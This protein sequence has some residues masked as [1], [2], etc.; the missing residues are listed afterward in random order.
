M[1]FA[2]SPE[3]AF[4]AER[5]LNRLKDLPKKKVRVLVTGHE[6]KIRQMS[7]VTVGEQRYYADRV[8]GSLYRK[9]TGCCLTSINMRID[10]ATRVR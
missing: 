9:D 5:Q 8:T 1:N 10:L 6:Q 2:F 7:M 3:G 4:L